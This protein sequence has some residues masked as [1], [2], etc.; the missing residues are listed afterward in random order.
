MM[1]NAFHC[2]LYESSNGDKLG[3]KKKEKV[4]LC[5]AETQKNL[6]HVYMRGWCNHVHDFGFCFFL[7]NKYTRPSVVL[8]CIRASHTLRL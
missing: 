8:N 3:L 5:L 4:R 1:Y 7:G 6:M 2:S